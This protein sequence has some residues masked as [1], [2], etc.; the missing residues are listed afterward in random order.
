VEGDKMDDPPLQL[1]M[2]DSLAKDI[3]DFRESQ[4]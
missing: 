4:L 3:S 1:A 2:L